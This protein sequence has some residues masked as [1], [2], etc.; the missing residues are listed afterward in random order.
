MRKQTKAYKVVQVRDGRFFSNSLNPK[1]EFCL[2]YR[3][4]R[5]T[6]PKIGKIF[7]FKYFEDAKNF[8]IN[9]S[10]YWAIFL[11]EATNLK[12]AKKMAAFEISDFWESRS[13]RKMNSIDVLPGTY[14]SDSA[15]LLKLVS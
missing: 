1:D 15:K 5:I 2:Q 11:V 9:K 6:K 13:G 14:F 12:K 7:L 4:G 3:I 8:R 10:K